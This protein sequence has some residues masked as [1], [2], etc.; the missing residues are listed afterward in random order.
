MEWAEYFQTAREWLTDTGLWKQVLEHAN[1]L[2]TIGGAAGFFV[3]V[4]NVPSIRRRRR[5]ANEDRQ[6]NLEQ[7]QQIGEVHAGFEMLAR[8]LT[9]SAAATSPGPQRIEQISDAL[10]AAEEDAETG[11][12]RMAEAL[13]LLEN[14]QTDKALLLFRAVAEEKSER[15]AKDS[16]DAAAAWRH[17]G[18]I[19][20]LADPAQARAAYA[21]AVELDPTNPESQFWH[22]WLQMDAGQIA[23]ARTAFERVLSLANTGATNRHIFWSRIGIVDVLVAQGNLADAL[24][25]YRAAMAIAE[26]LAV[27]D[28]HNAEWQRDLSVSHNKIGDVLVAQGNLADALV[29]YRAAMAIAERLA[30]DD[31]HN[32]EWQRDLS[33]SHNK[34]GDVLVAQRNLADALVSYRAAMTIVERLAEDD[35]H[36]AGWQR[37]LALSYGRVATI[38]VREAK[39]DDALLGFNKG[40]AIIAT[41]AVA[42]PDNA[43]LPNDLAWFDRQIAVLD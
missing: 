16:Q 25:S 40:R 37:D 29:S 27:D 39:R 10:E 11:D 3:L 20:G 23:A 22:G 15:I 9:E 1:I 7:S 31:P 21:K 38:Q 36:N 28:P 32:A 14:N 43:T 24:V 6:R 26:R 19:A 17:V 13:D 2:A 41:L 33:V 18:A 8:R 12:A 35:P 42:S 4:Y 34:I 30:V 5:E